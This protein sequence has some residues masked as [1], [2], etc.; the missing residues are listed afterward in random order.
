M[1]AGLARR[2]L[3]ASPLLVVKVLV[4]GHKSFFFPVTS[5][6]SLATLSKKTATLHSRRSG[7][8]TDQSYVPRGSREASPYVGFS[9]VG[10]HRSRGG[11]GRSPGIDTGS[12][13]PFRGV[14]PVG[15]GGT[16][17]RYPQVVSLNGRVAAPSPSN[18]VLCGSVSSRTAIRQRFAGLYT[19]TFPQVWVQPVY[20]GPLVDNASQGAYIEQRR[21]AAL[22]PCASDG[23][24]TND[25]GATCTGSCPPRPVAK[26][27][28]VTAGEVAIRRYPT[29]GVPPFPGPSHASGRSV[30]VF[31]ASG[32][33]APSSSFTVTPPV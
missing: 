27:A 12:G 8:T 16:Y 32:S 7:V 11:I 29:C 13:T 15:W 9:L 24:S 5:F 28:P 4:P 3:D 6:M 21:V 26:G 1:A 19:G 33:G 10:T 22:Q 2:S 23:G 18:T 20:T 30:G 25:P 17:G 14:H 31:S